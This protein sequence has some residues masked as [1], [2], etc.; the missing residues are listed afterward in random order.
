M[1]LKVKG[2]P[3]GIASILL[4]NGSIY[5]SPFKIYPPITETTTSKIE[6]HHVEAYNIRNV[7]LII[8]DEVTMMTVHALDAIDKLFLKVTKNNI[9]FGG[10]DLL[11]RGDFRQCLPVVKNGN[12]V[13][14]VE[15]TIKN[16]ATWSGI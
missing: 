8:I 7:S 15:S 10:K 16:S 12:R 2:N 1:Y 5:R 3:L 6:E 11:L 4:N 14:I 9:P 13:T